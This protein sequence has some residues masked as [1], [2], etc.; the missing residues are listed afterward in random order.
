MLLAWGI[1]FK[2]P[3]LTG[4]ILAVA[5]SLFLVATARMEEQENIRYFGPAYQEY[6][7]HTR[8][9]IPFLF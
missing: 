9:F 3:D 7:S 8:R 6:M 2:R 5:A 1:F 4:L